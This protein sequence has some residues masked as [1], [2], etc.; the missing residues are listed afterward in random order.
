MT[1][2]ASTRI[3]ARRR[4]RGWDTREGRFQGSFRC[5][6][7]HS[8]ALLPGYASS[9]HSCSADWAAPTELF[10]GPPN[11]VLGSADPTHQAAI[12]KLVSAGQVNCVPT[13]HV[14]LIE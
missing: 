6:A 8:G 2:Q 14:S 9:I 1:W 3:A 11:V 7:R 4:R 12:V 10:A 13:I 5:P